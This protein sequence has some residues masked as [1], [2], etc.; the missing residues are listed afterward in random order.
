MLPLCR[1]WKLSSIVVVL[2]ACSGQQ[3]W[4]PADVD[5]STTVDRLGAAGYSKLCSAFADHVRDTYR[6][7]LLVRAAC[8][9]Y[10]LDST[11]DAVMCGEVAQ[12]CTNNVPAPVETLI[13]RALSEAGCSTLAV[14]P[15]TCAVSVSTFTACLDAM[16]DQVGEA[17]YSLAC[18]GFGSPVPPDWYA[19]ELPSACKAIIDQC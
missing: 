18:T 19:L 8:T 13:G 17:Q 16:G 5:T 14:E 10:A 2:S 4:V 3:S 12:A 7:D 9:A 15:A 11:T 1:M 6:S